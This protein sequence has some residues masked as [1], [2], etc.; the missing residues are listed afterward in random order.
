MVPREILKKEIERYIRKDPTSVVLEYALGDK[1]A[2]MIIE[3]MK[4]FITFIPPGLDIDTVDDV[5][6]GNSRVMVIHKDGHFSPLHKDHI[7]DI[8]PTLINTHPIVHAP[9]I[10][11]AP[12]IIQADESC[13]PSCIIC[14]WILW[15]AP[16]LILG[17]I[18]SCE[19]PTEWRALSLTMTLLGMAGWAS[20]VC[21]YTFKIR[22]F[23]MFLPLL[24]MAASE[25]INIYCISRWG[26]NYSR[27]K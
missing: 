26:A 12:P 9:V 21:L 14:L 11:H 25:A 4:A 19:T 8:P 20:P 3:K 16:H 6:V 23:R 1:H 18:L 10:Y 13:L 24:V 2:Q 27:C 5:C 17:C 15:I 22:D 7:V